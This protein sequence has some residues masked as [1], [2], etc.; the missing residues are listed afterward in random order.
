[1]PLISVFLNYIRKLRQHIVKPQLISRFRHRHLRKRE[2]EK[3]LR[4]EFGLSRKKSVKW[5]KYVK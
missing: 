2:F 3:F 1:M 4:N 5:A